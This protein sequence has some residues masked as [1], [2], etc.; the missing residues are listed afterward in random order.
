MDKVK[1]IGAGAGGLFTSIIAAKS[2]TEVE[3]IEPEVSQRSGNFT[4]FFSGC[5]TLNEERLSPLNPL[6]KLIENSTLF[7][8][9]LNNVLINLESCGI[10]VCGNSL[11]RKNYLTA[12]GKIVSS[13]FVMKSMEFASLDE[14]KNKKTA[15]V[16]FGSHPFLFSKVLDNTQ[17]DIVR[18]EGDSLKLA[19]ESDSKGEEV[20]LK[21]LTPFMDKYE[22]LLTEPC[23]GIE[24]HQEIYSKLKEKANCIVGELPSFISGIPGLRLVSLLKREISKLP[25]KLI[26]GVKISE[27]IL[28]LESEVNVLSTGMQSIEETFMSRLLFVLNKT[29]PEIKTVDKIYIS[30]GLNPDP[31]S[32]HSV[33]NYHLYCD[34]LFRVLDHDGVPLKRKNLFSSGSLAVS[35]SGGMIGTLV[36]AY[37]SGEESSKKALS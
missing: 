4:F 3:L 7:K 1:V 8:D 21:S 15:L 25:V 32:P 35:I 12:E 5:F 34:S 16:F 29:F 30:E 31:L 9:T 17:I 33:F 27:G 37:I 22:L 6:V 24:K 11:H 28:N 2:G 13:Q 18:I 26:R 23:S 10:E 36:S 20:L 19:R 14:L